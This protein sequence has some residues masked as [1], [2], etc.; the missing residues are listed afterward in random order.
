MWQ[1]WKVEVFL[2]YSI[3]HLIFFLNILFY[4]E[5]EQGKNLRVRIF[6]AV[7]KQAGIW[8]RSLLT[9]A[10]RSS[11]NSSSTGIQCKEIVVYTEHK[12]ERSY[13]SKLAYEE[14]R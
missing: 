14:Q 4:N 6:S 13:L 12:K 7:G 5:R 11:V 8:R 3:L 2:V 10:E 1:I 9:M